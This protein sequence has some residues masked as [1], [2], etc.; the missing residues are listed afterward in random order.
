MIVVVLVLKMPVSTRL[1][2]Q[3]EGAPADCTTTVIVLSG[4][5]Y[6]LDIRF[7]GAALQ[8]AFAGTRYELENN[9]VA[10]KHIIDSL[11]QGKKEDVGTMKSLDSGNTEERG[12]MLN[13]ASGKVE[14]Y[15]EVWRTLQ[16]DPQGWILESVDEEGKCFIASLGAHYLSMQ[17]PAEGEAFN[18]LYQ[19][20]DF[21]AFQHGRGIR[22]QDIGAPPH[23]QDE[24]IF[25]QGRE[26]LVREV[27]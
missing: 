6:F 27:L 18:I 10:F 2:L 24:T 1:S 21:V 12:S 19:E 7:R 11:G 5:V 4:R 15:T 20:N 25:I 8:W 16:P 3:F 13:P 26:F 23:V 22:K 17:S 14:P 9:Q